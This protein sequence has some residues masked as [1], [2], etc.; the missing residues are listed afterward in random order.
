M[1]QLCR[2]L[3]IFGWLF[4]LQQ[5]TSAQLLWEIS[6]KGVKHKSY[7]FGTNKIASIAF[8]D[9]VPQLFA[10]FNK[11]E[12]VVT[13]MA[14]FTFQTQNLLRR[15]ALLP[16]STTLKDFYTPTEYKELEHAIK[17]TLQMEAGKLGRMKPAY[18]AQL[19]KEELYKKWLQYDADRSAEVFFQHVAEQKG[20]PIVGLD[21]VQESIYMLFEREPLQHQATELLRIMQYP[22]QEVKQARQLLHFYQQGELLEMVYEVTMRNNQTSIAYSDYQVYAKRN[23]LWV[24]QLGTMV[25]EKRSF[26]VVDALYLGGDKGLINQL[27][28]AGYKVRA[29]NR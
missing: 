22:E 14:V 24:K 9:S 1:S 12:Q 29:V 2:Y 21:N 15:A 3:L 13:E 4:T 6:G 20:L 17:Q 16:D 26:I 5:T 8:L 27:R 19:Y 23:E 25:Q 18:I 11:S 28:A 10:L 7:L